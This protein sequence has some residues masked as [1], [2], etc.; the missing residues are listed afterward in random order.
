MQIEEE[1]ESEYSIT[2]SSDVTSSGTEGED[3]SEQ[4]REAKRK[5][6]TRLQKIMV[7]I[8]FIFRTYSL[9]RMVGSCFKKKDG[10][11]HKTSL[12]W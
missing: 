6:R 8:N 11:P 7:K 12:H 1:V 2:A 9:E 4:I 3:I 10:A 5:R